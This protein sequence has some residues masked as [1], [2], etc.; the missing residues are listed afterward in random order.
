[1]VQGRSRHALLRRQWDCLSRQHELYHSGQQILNAKTCCLSP[2]LARRRL[3]ATHK[4]HP[5][6]AC[7]H[8][9]HAELATTV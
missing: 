9:L 8:Q 6:F 1:M 3:T 4:Y 2:L 5:H 7:V